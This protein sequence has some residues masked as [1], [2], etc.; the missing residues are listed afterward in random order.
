MF[1]PNLAFS[2]GV[3]AD[4]HINRTCRCIDFYGRLRRSRDGDVS[5]TAEQRCDVRDGAANVDAVEQ[6]GRLWHG[7]GGEDPH[8]AQRDSDFNDCERLSRLRLTSLGL[9]SWI[10][11]GRFV[12]YR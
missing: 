1:R 7:D 3:D 8:D 6:F 9:V 11:Y 5:R 4:D 2:D 10:A 12:L